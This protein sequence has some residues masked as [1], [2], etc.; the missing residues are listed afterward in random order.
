MDAWSKNLYTKFL[1]NLLKLRV[2]NHALFTY[3]TVSVAANIRLLDDKM[4]E[5]A[6]YHYSQE[7]SKQTYKYIKSIKPTKTRFRY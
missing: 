7:D 5:W 4:H 3:S 2:L 1:T 6:M